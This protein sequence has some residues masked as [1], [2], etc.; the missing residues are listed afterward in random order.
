M[1]SNS[2][3]EIDE[4]HQSIMAVHDIFWLDISVND[5]LRM[6]MLESLE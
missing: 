5:A 3:P 4:L 1:L 6:A 2:K